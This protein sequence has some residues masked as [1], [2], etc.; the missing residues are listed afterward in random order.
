MA[1][2]GTPEERQGTPLNT[3]SEP[4]PA[5][6]P[7]PSGH[8]SGMIQWVAWQRLPDIQ[9]KSYTHRRHPVEAVHN[10]MPTDGVAGH[11][12]NLTVTQVQQLPECVP[13]NPHE[14]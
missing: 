6:D 7:H 11:P 1:R 4:L 13:S 3:E 14:N 9:P 5:H 10:G 12:V 2:Q 8:V